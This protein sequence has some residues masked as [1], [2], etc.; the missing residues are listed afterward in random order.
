MLVPFSYVIYFRRIF[1]TACFPDFC[2]LLAVSML[3][4]IQRNLD[5]M[6]IGVINQCLIYLDNNYLDKYIIYDQ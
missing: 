2:L 5:G 6:E 1:V 4:K 3:L